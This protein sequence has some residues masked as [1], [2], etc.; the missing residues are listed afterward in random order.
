V[1]AQFGDAAAAGAGHGVVAHVRREGRVVQHAEVDEDRLQPLRP[2]EITHKSKFGAFGVQRADQDDR[3]LHNA[4]RC[5][6]ARHY[7]Q[8]IRR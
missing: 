7:K 2:D 1:A 6:P 3:F 8:F 5:A 4:P